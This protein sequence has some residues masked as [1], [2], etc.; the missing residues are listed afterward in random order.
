MQLQD[1]YMRVTDTTLCHALSKRNACIS[2]LYLHLGFG[3]SA[4]LPTAGQHQLNQQH[5][6]L[7]V[8]SAPHRLEPFGCQ[9]HN[10]VCHYSVLISGREGDSCQG[11]SAKIHVLRGSLPVYWVEPSQVQACGWS[12]WA[13]GCKLGTG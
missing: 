3:T 5:Q 4:L 6:H 13:E 2:F 7:L 1:M 12:W 8:R 9:L 11:T 10:L